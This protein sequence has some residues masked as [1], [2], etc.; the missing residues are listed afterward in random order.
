MLLAPAPSW[1]EVIR[2]A[3][4][5]N[6]KTTLEVLAKK[7]EAHT[8]HHVILVSGSTGKHYAQIIH[9]APFDAFFAADSKRPKRLEKEGLAITGSRF[10]YAL[11]KIIL[12]SPKTN[13]VDPSG[14]ILKKGE[15]RHLALA[16]PRLAPYGRAA[17]EVLQTL[18]LWKQL[19]T[20]LVR[21][22]N[23]SQTFQFIAS[24]NAELGFIAYSQMKT[25]SDS[26][27]STWEIPENLYHPIEQQAILL[28]D[29]VSTR[30]FLRFVRGKIAQKIIKTHGYLI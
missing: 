14:L 19:R 24:G 5:S 13:Y 20:R 7:F 3:V 17:R 16:N 18:G 11:G 28:K 6:F 2:V 22:E 23:I 30:A 12:W 1:A 25:F 26:A 9:G 8:V 10:T 29:R 4:A 15:F 21:G 27:G